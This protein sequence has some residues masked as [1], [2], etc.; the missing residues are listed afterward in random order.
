M[1]VDVKPF[2]FLQRDEFDALTV[3]EKNAYAHR[4][5]DGLPGGPAAVIENEV[6]VEFMRRFF[7]YLQW[8]NLAPDDYERNVSRPLWGTLWEMAEEV[9]EVLE[10][11]ITDPDISESDKPA[12]REKI[13]ELQAIVDQK[14]TLSAIPE[15][16]GPPRP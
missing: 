13:A 1:L 14:R 6:Q 11:G 16:P 3:D 4:L 12:I 15:T 2:A 8:V 5:R 7:E 10:A 9:L